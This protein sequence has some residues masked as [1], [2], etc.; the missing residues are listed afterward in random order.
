MK[1][2]A[3]LLSK[4]QSNWKALPTSVKQIFSKT[5]LPLR[6]I[7]LALVLCLRFQYQSV[8]LKIMWTTSPFRMCPNKASQIKQ[9]YSKKRL[10]NQQWPLMS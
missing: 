6:K 8:E 10:E 3:G 7:N 4:T 5:L 2:N 9:N 1:S